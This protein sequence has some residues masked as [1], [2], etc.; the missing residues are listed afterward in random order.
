MLRIFTLLAHCLQLCSLS[1]VGDGV[2]VLGYS[3]EKFPRTIILLT[4]FATNGA[5]GLPDCT[6]FYSY[7]HGSIVGKS[8]LEQ[9][10][11]AS[12]PALRVLT[13]RTPL[14]QERVCVTTHLRKTLHMFQSYQDRNYYICTS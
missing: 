8:H 5:Q 7:N 9:L 2:C 14:W 13:D 4:W 6:L 3:E 12:L 10:H 11:L 1:H